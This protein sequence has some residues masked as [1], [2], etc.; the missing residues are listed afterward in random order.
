M[1]NDSFQPEAPPWSDALVVICSKCGKKL[2]SK[3]NEDPSEELKGELKSRV[4]EEGLKHQLRVVTSSCMDLCPKDR[5]AVAVIRRDGRPAVDTFS[6]TLETSR[7]A[8]WK[9]ISK[10]D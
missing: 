1:K 2:A 9:K 3:E 8:L 6:V 7:D 4:K 5:I 10:K